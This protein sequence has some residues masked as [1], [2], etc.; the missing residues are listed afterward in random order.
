M[1]GALAADVLGPEVDAPLMAGADVLAPE[2]P[3]V[4]AP[5]LTW[6]ASACGG[7]GR[8]E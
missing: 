1:A 6:E 2:A 7:C 4:D 8:V 3:E 5:E